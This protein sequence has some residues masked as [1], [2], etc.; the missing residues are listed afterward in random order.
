MYS[1]AETGVNETE[2]GLLV[3]DIIVSFEI[4]SYIADCAKVKQLI[5]KP[6]KIM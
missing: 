6:N 3:A 5:T 2:S 1:E 4:V